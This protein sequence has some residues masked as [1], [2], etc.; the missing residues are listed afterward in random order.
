V[1]ESSQLNQ[2]IEDPSKC[3]QRHLLS[4]PGGCGNMLWQQQ[5]A[6]VPTG[7]TAD[8]TAIGDIEMNS[9]WTEQRLS[10]ADSLDS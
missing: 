5:R 8:I 7:G 4:L 2:I 3:L 9:L 1:I 10:V 6:V